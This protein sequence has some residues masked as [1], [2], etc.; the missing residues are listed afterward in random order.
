VNWTG[1]VVLRNRQSFG[2]PID[3][4]GMG[5]PIPTQAVALICPNLLSHISQQPLPPI[6]AP[7]HDSALAFQNTASTTA[8]GNVLAYEE[9]QSTTARTR[10]LFTPQDTLKQGL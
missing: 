3:H 5:K 7:C 1:N 8:S 10:S 4:D 6:L 2:E 9:L